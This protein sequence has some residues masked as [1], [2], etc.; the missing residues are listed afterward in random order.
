MVQCLSYLLIIR[1]VLVALGIFLMWGIIALFTPVP[2]S[3]N[4]PFIE[5]ILKKHGS[6]KEMEIGAN[7]AHGEVCTNTN[8]I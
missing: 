5:N 3:D 7:T 2:N 4:N 8:S 6:L 1:A